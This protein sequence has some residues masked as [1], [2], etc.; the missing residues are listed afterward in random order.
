MAKPAISLNSA[1]DDGLADRLAK[2]E[3]TVHGTVE[4][5]YKNGLTYKV[6]QVNVGLSKVTL[7]LNRW[8]F[9]LLGA[10]AASGVLNG[11]AAKTI[12]ELLKGLAQ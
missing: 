12:G 2:L 6:D 10:F 5:D 3:Y 1:R 8:G 4:E 7:W 11:S 9:I